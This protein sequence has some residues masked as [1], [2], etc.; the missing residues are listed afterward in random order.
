MI[1]L[2]IAR[3]VPELGGVEYLVKYPTP[4]S[5]STNLPILK[6]DRLIPNLVLICLLL[7]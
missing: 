5:S 3:L 2:K 7:S 4:P 6:I 1:I